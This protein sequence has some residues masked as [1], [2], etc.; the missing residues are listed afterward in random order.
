[1]SALDRP[2]WCPDAACL[3]LTGYAAR[4]CVGRLPEKVPHDHMFNTHSFCLEGKSIGMAN[5]QRAINDADAYYLTRCMQ[6]VRDDVTAHGLY[7]QGKGS[8]YDQRGGAP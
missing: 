8:V 4:M 2:N 5:E 1:M 6:A 3:C 7:C